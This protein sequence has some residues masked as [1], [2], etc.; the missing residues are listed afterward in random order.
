MLLGERKWPPGQNCGKWI[1][2]KTP[3]AE[4]TRVL[5]INACLVASRL[6]SKI[7]RGAVQHLGKSDSWGSYVWHLVSALLC[8]S[9]S[10]VRQVMKD[11][12]RNGAMWTPYSRQAAADAESVSCSATH[13]QEA[14]S[15]APGEDV[16]FT[17][18]I[19][20]VRFAIGSAAEGR[21]FRS[22]QRD[23]W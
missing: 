12:Q 5:V 7:L 16:A 4:Q 23:V 15:S 1:D 2:Q 20:V 22:F 10:T 17:S 3:L 21:S 9:I 8:I 13:D 14:G 19:P 11:G 6:P 18:L